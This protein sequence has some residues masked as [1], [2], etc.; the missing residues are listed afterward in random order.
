MAKRAPRLDRGA[1]LLSVGVTALPSLMKD[2]WG[3]LDLA[4]QT[5]TGCEA[6]RETC[7]TGGGILLAAA[8]RGGARSEEHTPELQSQ[9]NLVCRLLLEKK[10]NNINHTV[11]SHQ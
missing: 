1:L 8:G 4:G 10:K 7:A 11:P 6:R 5:S 2:G 3:G 9:P